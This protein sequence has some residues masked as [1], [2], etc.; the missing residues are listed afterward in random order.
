[1]HYYQQGLLHL[2]NTIGDKLFSDVAKDFILFEQ[3]QKHTKEYAWL[4]IFNFIG[5][6]MTPERL[7]EQIQNLDNFHTESPY[8][9]DKLISKNLQFAI[10][11]MHDAGYIKQ[12]GAEYFSIFSEKVLPFLRAVA[13]K[14]G[15]TYREFMCLSILE[16]DR[17]LQGELK[18]EDL[19]KKA[20]Q[21]ININDWAVIGGEGGKM[22]FIEESVDIKLLVD[23]MVPRIEEG[24]Q[25]LSGQIG[26]RGKYTGPVCIVMN[27]YDFHKLQTNDVLVT[28]MT[29]PDFIVLMQKSGAIITDIGG[30]LCHA[31]IVSREVKKPCIIGTKF[32]TQL[33]QDGDLV[34]V[35]AEAGIVRILEKNIDNTILEKKWEF[36]SERQMSFHMMHL[37]HVGY[38]ELNSLLGTNLT[39]TLYYTKN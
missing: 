35:D 28:T 29:T 31:A 10:A 1:M 27:T 20:A 32:A 30:L 19:K 21:R 14:I 13:E 6:P 33:L 2:K 3:L 36:S 24:T 8:I 18:T 23:K 5:E 16:I 17:A 12:A 7:F 37:F 4:E 34:E 39:T 22:I 15:V 26:N 9:P 25:E 38:S 11:C